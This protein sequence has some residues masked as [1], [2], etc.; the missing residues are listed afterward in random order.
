ML[1]RNIL[2]N[3][4][5]VVCWDECWR[6][7]RE[8]VELRHFISTLSTTFA[9]RSTCR[10]HRALVKACE[11]KDWLSDHL[12]VYSDAANWDNSYA[13]CSNAAF[14][15]LAVL[16]WLFRNDAKFWW[17]FL[18]LFAPRQCVPRFN[19][20]ELTNDKTKTIH[21]PDIWILQPVEDIKCLSVESHLFS[22]QKQ[23]PSA[24][25]IELLRSQ[26]V[27]ISQSW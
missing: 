21:L 26:Q 3:W 27:Q 9:V 11:S 13:D 18:G 12:A 25:H 16:R 17:G 2:L 20:N 22:P 6:V 14:S 10:T 24:D 19:C 5:H 7:L 1:R 15:G 4:L 8:R 23:I